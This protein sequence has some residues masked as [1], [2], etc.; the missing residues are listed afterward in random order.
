MRAGAGSRP[1]TMRE[2][3]LAGCEVAEAMSDTYRLQEPVER[4][5]TDGSSQLRCRHDRRALP[6]RHNA[7]REE[8]RLLLILTIAPARA[9]HGC[10]QQ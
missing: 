1:K 4:Y 3:K 8:H 6:R 9:A 5:S 2:S 10:Q 7:H